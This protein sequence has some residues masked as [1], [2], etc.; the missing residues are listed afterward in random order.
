FPYW[1]LFRISC[2]GCGF[3]AMC[4]LRLVLPADLSQ[5]GLKSTPSP[6]IRTGLQDPWAAKWQAWLVMNEQHPV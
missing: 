4:S 1:G 5:Q 2:F 3:A 6:K